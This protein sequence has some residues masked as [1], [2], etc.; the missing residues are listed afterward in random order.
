MHVLLV[1]YSAPPHTTPRSSRVAS[2]ARHL[3]RLGHT[4][5]ILSADLGGDDQGLIDKVA[6]THRVVTSAGPLATMRARRPAAAGSGGG[7]PTLRTRARRFAQQLVIPEW[8]I[9]W[10]LSTSVRRLGLERPDIIVA[11]S[12]RFSGVVLA[13]TLARRWDVPFVIDYGDPWS[14][15]RDPDRPDWR[16]PIDH[17]LERRILA[18][19]AGVI[20]NTDAQ[21]TG[22]I[23]RFG[24]ERITCLPNGFD[25]E[26]Y[27]PRP[28]V[29]PGELRHLG[30]LYNIRLP[31]D[32]LSRALERT[33]AFDRVVS[34]GR[35]DRAD[36]PPGF[37]E[38]AFV[39]FHESL[40]LM[41]EAG[42]LLVVGNLGGIQI[43]SKVYTYLGSGRPIL[44]LV[45]GKDDVIA[46]L[47]VGEQ[48]TACLNDDESVT[49]ALLALKER[50]P[51][52]FEPPAKWS[53]ATIGRD[54]TTFLEG[55]L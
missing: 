53:W 45:E 37:E 20:V 33:H 29:V 27:G 39:P 9:E 22:M 12:P 41:Q 54:Y 11:F 47:D 43:P 48:L 2:A 15:R 26:D 32:A 4:V 35:R 55:C 23:E 38:R 49:E 6:G 34:Y 5:A 19:S 31:L 51:R 1:S 36:L 7:R 42:A 10:A 17:A 14:W 18:S 52:T 40:R 50:V 44:A 16:K 28:A 13:S 21:R 3:M 46:R 24:I 8:E 25:P 30:H